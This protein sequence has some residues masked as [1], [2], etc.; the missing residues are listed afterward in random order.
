LST[1]QSWRSRVAAALPIGTPPLD[2]YA[3][4]APAQPAIGEPGRS[5]VTLRWWDVSIHRPATLALQIAEFPV[6]TP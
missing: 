4:I 6:A 5:D 3:D 1:M 2:G